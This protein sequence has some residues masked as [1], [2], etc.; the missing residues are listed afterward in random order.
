MSGT[1]F[2]LLAE[3]DRLRSMG[4]GFRSRRSSFDLGDGMTLLLVMTA[5]VV[6]LYLLSRYLNRRDGNQ[7]YHSPRSLF[8]ELCGAHGLSFHNRRLL[9]KLASIQNLADPTLLFLEPERFEE[10]NIA[11][12]LRDHKADLLAIRDRIFA[13]RIEA[14]E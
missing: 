13:K 1:F 6:A 11:G 2:F 9:K 4:S 10:S 5:L 7:S 14:E 3:A 12:E 8:R